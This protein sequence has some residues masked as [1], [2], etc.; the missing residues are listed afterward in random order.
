MLWCCLGRGPELEV[1]DQLL[2][3]PYSNSTGFGSGSTAGAG[4]GNKTADGFENDSHNGMPHAV[5]RLG[6]RLS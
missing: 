6:T 4:W 3:D 2:Q 5:R 1:V